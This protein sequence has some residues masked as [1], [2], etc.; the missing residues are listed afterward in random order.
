MSQASR[1]VVPR[2]NQHVG[3]MASHLRD[4]NRMNPPTF[5]GYKV[6]ENP[7]YFIDY[8]YNILYAMELTTSEKAELAT[9]QLKDVGKAWYVQWRDNRPLRGE[10]VTWEVF[11]KAFLDRFFHR[12]KLEAKVMEFINSSRMYECAW[13]ILEIQ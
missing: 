1:E 4:F 13:I 3:T 7:Q 11:K 9:Y 12:E 5:Y 8:V 10:P 2:E 6:Y